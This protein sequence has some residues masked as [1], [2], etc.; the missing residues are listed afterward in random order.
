MKF[1]LLISL[2]LLGT[3]NQIWS[4]QTL[5]QIDVL[6]RQQ[7][8]LQHARIELRE[9]SGSEQL[10]AITDRSGSCSFTIT[11]GSIWKLWIDGFYYKQYSFERTDDVMSETSVSITHDTA[12]INRLKQQ[13][14]S[15]KG[16]RMDTLKFTHAAV[17]PR[18]GYYISV[19]RVRDKNNT[20]VPGIP[21]SFVDRSRGTGVTAFSD[22][23][24]QL[25]LQL[26]HSTNY[27]IDVADQLNAYTQDMDA[28]ENITAY[29]T[30]LYDPYPLKEVKRK[31]TVSQVFPS[32]QERHLS[33][34]WF[35][36]TMNR[37]K[38]RI[39]RQPVYLNE[40]GAN[41]VYEGYT[42]SSGKVIFLLPHG[43]KYLVHFRFQRD[44]DVVDLSDSRQDAY[45]FLQLKYDPE[46]KLVNR[47]LYIPKTE[48]LIPIDFKKYLPHE[49]MPADDRGWTISAKQ[50]RVSKLE[51]K[52]DQLVQ[53]ELRTVSSSSII[54]PPLNIALLLDVSGSMAGYERIES[55]KSGL[56]KLI[57]I[58]DKK[59]RISIIQYSEKANLLLPSRVIG[60]D[61]ALI[62]QLI[63]QLEAGGSTNMLPA[64]QIGYE[65][66]MTFYS[67]EALNIAVILSDGYDGNPID[68][69]LKV[70][71]P[72]RD[73]IFCTTVGVGMD[74][75]Q[76]LLD[77]LATFVGGDYNFH[78]E[79]AGL[80][81][82][83]PQ[84]VQR[85]LNPLEKNVI[86][87]VE[88]GKGWN[89]IALHGAQPSEKMPGRARF[90]VPYIY[91]GMESPFLLH[92]SGNGDPNSIRYSWKVDGKPLARESS[93]IPLFPLPESSRKMLFV[94]GAQQYILAMAGL[95]E[96]GRNKEA[97]LALEKAFDLL[98]QL[99]PDT[100]DPD[101]KKLISDLEHYREAF[102]NLEILK[103]IRA[104]DV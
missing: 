51:G 48:A 97:S 17:A 80:T 32:N 62:Q 4:Q 28:E 25:T 86:V 6:N 85:F 2:F 31:D 23:Q 103:K 50:F 49:I 78:S 12:H 42:D 74:Y 1:L 104:E 16:I 8:P 54:R 91:A 10:H 18:K 61:T 63:V 5:V 71:R 87:E 40:I 36:L 72:Y 41:T 73:K 83:I 96:Q 94:A 9:E 75:N 35:E 29:K 15:R 59:D 84:A 76:G 82:I 68:S 90:R 93:D 45:A 98:R 3:I 24:G 67:A 56:A 47:N 55:L 69:L 26:P 65:Q 52:T 89:L 70:Q 38:G 43:K 53:L 20:P 102:R 27:D 33:R 30:V 95:F 58:L 99:Q 37:T 60:S 19:V 81:D 14:F 57:R 7:K 64:L 39:Y 22:R 92:F 66:I 77:K 101:I 88:Y 100:S 21:I 79:G 34:A 46:D 11:S 13:S 44:V